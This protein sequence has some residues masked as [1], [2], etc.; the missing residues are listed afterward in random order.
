MAIFAPPLRRSLQELRD[1]PEGR[2]VRKDIRSTG[3][4]GGTDLST[5]DT[6][7][8]KGYFVDFSAD[9]AQFETLFHR[10]A[11][12]GAWK[13]WTP[14]YA[15]ITVDNG[16]VVSRYV[17]IG[18]R[19]LAQFMLTFGSGTTMGTAHT[20]SFP[21]A[22]DPSFTAS[23]LNL[24]PAMLTETGVAINH[25][26]VQRITTLTARVLVLNAA[27]TYLLDSNVS[28]T[29]PFTWGTGDILSFNIAYET[30]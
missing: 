4:D 12:L 18:D 6:A 11:D 2:V 5:V 30:T 17:Q 16:T 13:T 19:V 21:V 20:I 9:A 23:R 27:S 7:A 28:A 29:V 10:G 14:T 26:Y 25:G 8:T 15:N 22:A 3:W 1:E 24:G